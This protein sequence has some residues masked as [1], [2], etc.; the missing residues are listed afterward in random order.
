MKNKEEKKKEN[1]GDNDLKSKNGERTSKNTLE[2][3]CEI[4]HLQLDRESG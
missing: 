2:M 3:C 1:G 4:H